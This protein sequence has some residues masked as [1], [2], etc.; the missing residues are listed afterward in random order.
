MGKRGR[1]PKLNKLAVTAAVMRTTGKPMTQIAE[2]LGYGATRD[3]TKIIDR[4][5][6]EILAEIVAKIN[7]REQD[8]APERDKAAAALRGLTQACNRL[9]CVIRSML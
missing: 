5:H 7:A 4:Q 8:L 3:L 6:D 9:V 2:E 1:R